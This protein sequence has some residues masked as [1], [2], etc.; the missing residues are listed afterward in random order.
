M[1][2]SNP[3]T[4]DYLCDVLRSELDLTDD[5]V[6]IYNQ[7]FNIPN[8]SHLF[9]GIEYKFSKVFAAK[10]TTEDVSSTFSERQGVNTQE[11]YAIILFSRNIEAL[12]MKERAVMALSSVYSRQQGDSHGF[13]I[14]RIGQIQDLSS[15]EGAAILY[16]YEISVVMLC[17][18]EHIKTIPWY[19]T[20]PMQVTVEDGDDTTVDVT[21]SYPT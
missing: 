16:R 11:H 15:L 19:G 17:R 6:N 20:F 9:V 21:Q 4:I 5:R 13:K 1:I 8:D 2:T 12:Q 14:A 7:K 10:S 18:Y 3:T